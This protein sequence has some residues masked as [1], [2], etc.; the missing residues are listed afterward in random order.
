MTDNHIQATPYE[1]WL[2]KEG[3]PVIR[4]YS[5]SALHQLELAPWPRL[6]ARGAYIDLVGMEKF[7]G[8]Y[9]AEIP[10]GGELQPEKHMYEEFIY[11]SSGGG[12]AEVWQDGGPARS[13]PW[14]PGSLFSPPL[15]TWHRLRNTG[16]EAVRLV[17]VTTAPIIMDFFHNEDFIFNCPYSFGDRYDGGPDYFVPESQ[18]TFLEEDRRWLW[19]TNLAPDIREV[20]I[21]LLERKGTEVRITIVEAAGNVLAT[22]LSEWPAGRYHK[23]HYH[24]AGAILLILK[25][26]GYTLIWPKDAGT[27]PY[28][29]GRGDQV[30]RIDWQEG[31]LYSPPDGWFHQHFNTGPQ[32]ARQLAL[33]YGSRKHPM[34][35][36]L[37]RK[38]GQFSGTMISLKEGGTVIEYEL[39]DPQIHQLFEEA[40]AKTGVACQMHPQM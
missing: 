17:A 15:N 11:I 37:I 36:E 4:V 9:V 34:G 29:E 14:Q 27:R 40:L 2:E 39:E 25:G 22:H 28:L 38:G 12:E 35:W 24:A 16:S 6:G 26:S 13:F 1:K 21:D 32:P 23:A 19:R 10:P 20:P 5:V 3:L 31:S 8:M 7:T 33:R 30:V 18:R